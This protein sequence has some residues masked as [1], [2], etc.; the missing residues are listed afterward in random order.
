MILK[1][2]F[3]HPLGAMDTPSGREGFRGFRG[4]GGR[5]AADFEKGARLT[6]QVR[7]SRGGGLCRRVVFADA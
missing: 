2:W 5:F 3:H 4:K 7:A 6:A 1:P